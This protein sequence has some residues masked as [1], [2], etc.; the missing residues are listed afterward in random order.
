MTLKDLDAAEVVAE[1]GYWMP[2]GMGIGFAV[3]VLLAFSFLPI[4]VL[5]FL[6]LEK[7]QGVKNQLLISGCRYSAYWL[8]NLVWDVAFALA[9]VAVCFTVFSTMEMSASTRGAPQPS[10]IAGKRK[11]VEHQLHAIF[12]TKSV[13]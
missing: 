9:P 6:M 5:N 10:M 11:N 2:L 12:S 4:G 1:A 13:C 3:V 7:Q 8:S